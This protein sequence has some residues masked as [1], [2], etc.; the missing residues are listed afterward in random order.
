MIIGFVPISIDNYIKNH[1]ETS[2]TEIKNDMRKKLKTALT[3]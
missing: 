2:Q 3:G 1:L